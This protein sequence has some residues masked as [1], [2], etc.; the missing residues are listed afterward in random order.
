MEIKFELTEAQATV[1]K[2]VIAL[3][4]RKD[5]T[6]HEACKNVIVRWIIQVKQQMVAKELA[7]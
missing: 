5:A 4:D 3:S 6:E 2:E 7:G 1:L